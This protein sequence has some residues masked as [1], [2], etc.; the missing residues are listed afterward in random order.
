[1]AGKYGYAGRILRVDLSSGRTTTVPTLDYADRFLGGRGIAAKIYWDEVSPE[2]KALEPDNRLIFITGPLAGVSP[3]VGAVRWLVCGKS[4]V[5]TPEQFS[6]CNLGGSWG[7]ELKFAGYDGVIVQGKSDKPV[8]ISIEDG[9][10]EIK[11][12]SALWGKSTLDTR[13]IL[14]KELGSQ[15]RVVATGPAGEHMSTIA[16]I[17]ADNDASGSSGF[18]AVMGSKNLKAIAVRG[19]GKIATAGREKL[20]ELTRHIRQMRRTS[21]QGESI[22]GGSVTPD[23]K[24][25]DICRGCSLGCERNV[26]ESKDGRKGKFICG[27][28]GFYSGR[29]GRYYGDKD[30][31]EVPFQAAM[32][33]NDYGLDVFAIGPM[34]AWLS[35]CNRAGIL[36]DEN[37]GIPLS[38]MGSVDFIETLLKKVSLREGFGDV[39]AD[40]IVRASEL[41]GKDSGKLITDYLTKG[42]QGLAYDPRY[43]ITTGLLYA[44]EPRLP[45][46]QLHETSRLVLGWLSWVGK[47]GRAYLSTDICRAIAK[48]FWGTELAFDLSTYEG[49]ALTAINIQNREYAKESMILCDWIFPIMTVEFSE[50]HIGD[51]SLESQIVSAALGEEIDEEGLYK[52]GERVVNLQRAILTREARGSDTIADFHFTVPQRDD[53]MNPRGIAPGKDGEIIVRKGAMLDRVKF[54]EMKREYY[55]LRGW[56]AASGLQTKAKLEEL[57]LKDVADGLEKRKLIV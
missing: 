10:A 6:Y 25:L 50:D 40:G 47:S 18:G 22:W 12:A 8:Y 21:S 52:I 39:L 3:G 26:Y 27:Q 54:E 5:T 31:H 11:N 30:W 56:D 9:T 42:E 32:L 15:T 20:T 35:R 33:A 55:Q 19:S 45:I 29:A 16:T 49:K 57:N 1:M 17:L 43:F 28:V 44:M 51:P 34:M 23:K 53:P 38:R 37:T 36:T 4:P 2:V 13:E 14:K 46:Q 48:R 41:V 7:T 24:K